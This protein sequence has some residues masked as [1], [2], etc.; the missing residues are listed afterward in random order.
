MCRVSYTVYTC[1]YIDT[2]YNGCP[3][4]NYNAAAGTYQCADNLI[5]EDSPMGS[6]D[7]PCQK[8]EC[9]AC[10]QVQQHYQRLL[11]E[12]SSS[13]TS[14]NA[15]TTRQQGHAQH[16][17]SLPDSRTEG[18]YSLD[19]EQYGSAQVSSMSATQT[20]AQQCYAGKPQHNRDSFR[21]PL[22]EGPRNQ[23]GVTQQ[24]PERNPGN[25][26]RRDFHWADGDYYR[27]NYP[28][29][30]DPNEVERRRR[31]DRCVPH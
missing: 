25:T 22:R 30:S 21:S 15:A 10:S 9:D 27:T 5:Y 18:Q 28:T 31:E 23:D 20:T 16:Y 19:R 7:Y 3:Y 11:N 8:A 17:A 29:T 24:A 2:H 1:G 13:S 26:R 6:S 14:S 4:G 12:V